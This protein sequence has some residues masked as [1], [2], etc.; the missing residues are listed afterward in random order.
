MVFGFR[1]GLGDI[2][3][4]SSLGGLGVYAPED[5]VHQLAKKI[6]FSHNNLDYT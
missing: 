1:K 3:E 2:L 4:S 6:S 5:R